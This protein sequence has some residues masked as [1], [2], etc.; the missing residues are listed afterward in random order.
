MA[1]IMS[2]SGAIQPISAVHHQRASNP[3][4]PKG[5]AVRDVDV[6]MA[7]FDSPEQIHEPLDPIEERNL[8]RKV[9]KTTHLLPRG[10]VTNP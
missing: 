5:V 4:P 2:K 10:R 6:A 3:P 9:R 1:V 8:V 7:L